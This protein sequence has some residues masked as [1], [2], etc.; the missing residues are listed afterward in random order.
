MPYPYSAKCGNNY[1]KGKIEICPH[2]VFVVRAELSFI[3]K[4]RLLIYAPLQ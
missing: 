4:A 3:E 2:I 1:K